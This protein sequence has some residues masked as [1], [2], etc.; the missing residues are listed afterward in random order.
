MNAKPP[1]APFILLALA[2]VGVG[3]TLYLAWH[4]YLNLV[5]GCAIG[6]CETVLQSEYSRFL[7]LPWSYFGLV[8]Y[9]YL[10]GLS[11]LLVIDPRSRG[12]TL[13][14]TLYSGI[15]ALY[16]VWAIFYIQLTVIGALCLYCAISALITWLAF[17]TAGW[18]YRATRDETA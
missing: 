8:Y 9:V 13:G 18:H 15:G 7:G 17:G 1:L 14:A 4:Q 6:G 2:L 12:L 11:I 3:D 16:S 10:V 5:P